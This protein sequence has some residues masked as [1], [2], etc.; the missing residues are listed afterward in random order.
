MVEEII[1][2]NKNKIYT[3][4]ADCI[5]HL[6][7]LLS[8]N[9]HLIDRMDPVE[10]PG[11]KSITNL[12]SAVFR[13]YTGSKEWLK[14]DNPFKNCATL[15]F[16][17][18][19]NHPFHNGNK[20][21]AFLAMIKHLF[22]NGYV[23]KPDTRHD[24]IYDVLVAI[25]DNNLEGEFGVTDGNGKRLFRQG[26]TKERWS[27]EK[28]IEVISHW[29]RQCCESKNVCLKSKI[30]VQ[31]LSEILEKKS[32]YM[33]INGTWL[34]LYQIRSK[35]ILGLISTGK[36]R[37]NIKTYGMGN[38][39]SEIGIK[40]INQI[41]KDYGLTQKDGFDNKAFYDTETFIDQ[42]IIAYK[43]VIYKLSQT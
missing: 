34:T 23:I 40:L 14:Y 30:R 41:R 20:R 17:L 25:A 22:E 4:T 2:A 42:E 3:L 21:V 15:M 12:E 35:K 36:E 37:Y 1:L 26:K 39:L 10:P 9:Y 33:E 11:I 24:E 6:H 31:R 5:I 13:Q 27:D 19:K 38:S 32:I 16:G 28:N 7:D 43:K 29:L 18:I 8:K